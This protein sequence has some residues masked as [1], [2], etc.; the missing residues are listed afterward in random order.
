MLLALST[1]SEQGQDLYAKVGLATRRDENSG[2]RDLGYF[3]H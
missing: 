1:G 3:G 2:G